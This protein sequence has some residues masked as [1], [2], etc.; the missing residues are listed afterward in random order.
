[1][2]ALFLVALA[3]M[4]GCAPPEPAAPPPIDEPPPVAR[5]ASPEKACEPVELAVAGVDQ[6]ISVLTKHVNAR[7]SKALFELFSP[8]MKEAVD[9]D[10][11]AL[12]VNGLVNDNGKIT[13]ATRLPGVGND[14]HGVFVVTFEKGEK[15]HIDLTVSPE[16]KILGL[17]IAAPPA[18]DPEVTKTTLPLALPFRGQWLVFWG[19]DTLA[20]NQHV[21]HKSQRR[22]AD[23][24]Q[25]GADKKTHSGDGKKNSDYLAYGEEILAAADG[26]VETM[27]DGVPENEPGVLNPYFATGNTVILRHDDRTFSVYAHLQPGKLRV[28]KGQAVKRGA[29]LGLCGNSGN[30]SEPHLHF[31]LQDGAR[32]DQSFGV[33]AVFQK[34]P[35]TRNGKTEESA[36]YT[37]LKGDLI[38]K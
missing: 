1:M 25:V 5:P 19:G 20:V 36:S 35:V 3:G 2:R 38:G 18:P 15:L 10:K 30:S 4:A 31:Q 16:G 13:S 9:L 6:T 22:A 23:L 32:F 7:E 14:K 29:V 33:E 24:V 17:R 27:I 12:I 11:T 21:T 37:F 34:V 8:Q 26:K 28:K